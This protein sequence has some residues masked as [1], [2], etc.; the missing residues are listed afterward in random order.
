[1]KRERIILWFVLISLLSLHAQ[2]Q[3]LSVASFKLLE[4]DMTARITD[5]KID[6]NGDKCAIVKVVTAQTGFVFEG[7]MLGIIATVRKTGEYWVYLPYGAKRLTIKHDKLGVLRNYFYTETIEKATVYELVLT[8]GKVVTVV[9]EPEIENVYL[10]ITSTPTDADVYIDDQATGK[11]TP[12]SQ[13]LS[14]GRHSYRVSKEMY[15]T[16]AGVFVLSAEE[17][18][19]AIVA[20]LKPQFGS[21]SIQTTPESGAEISL[22]SLPTGKTTPC[23]LEK[24]PSGERRITARKQWY[25]TKTVIVKLADGENKT[26]KIP[27]MPTFATINITATNNAKIYIDDTYQ[28]T[29]SYQGR[30]S[31]GWHTFEARLENHKPH[32]VEQEV[33]KGEQINLQLSAIPKY[34]KIDI[35]TTP[36]DANI[37]INNKDYGKTPKTIRQIQVGEY[38]VTFSKQGY[39]TLTRQIT[40]REGKTTEI[41]ETLPAG[42]TVTIN[43]QP[44]GASLYISDAYQGKCPQTLSLTFGTHRIK[45]NGISE[46]EETTHTITIQR[47]GKIRFTL[48]LNSKVPEGFVFV[49]GGTFQMGSNKGDG[50]EKPVHSVTVSD[51]Y[52]GKYE[53]TQKQWREVM[54]N[55]PSRFKGDNLPVEKVSWNDIQQ[56]LR[57]LNAKTGKTYRLPTEAE[58]GYA[59]RGGAKSRGYKY[60]GSN[61][62]DEVA[63]YGYSKSGKKTHPVGQKKPN[64]L[65]IYDMSGNVW[66]WC[67]DWKGSYSSS[68]QT[69]P[70]GASSGSRRVHRGGSWVNIASYSRVVNRSSSMPDGR[71]S[72]LGFRLVVVP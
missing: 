43:S 35:M 54:G 10:T 72:Y 50:D 48:P 26:V 62:I 60:A 65:G 55:N 61:N 37:S 7:G 58:W 4:R 14:Q 31:A 20:N 9:E 8:S 16:E 42:L 59:A 27:L 32:K 19:K 13:K 69:N 41:N 53:V 29:A 12:F 21:L 49:K 18:R 46:Y 70:T 38:A 15:H 64:E 1:M 17:G 71:D 40:V 66:E 45:L 39:G 11:R 33:E 24:V 2:A 57:K 36:F 47:G 56:F 52:M 5:P 67:S 68:S 28:A 3:R 63:W 23:T 34:G 22:E 44:Q 25:E 30:V 51:F 6:Q